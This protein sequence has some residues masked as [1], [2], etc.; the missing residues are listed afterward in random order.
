MTVG[1]A[2]CLFRLPKQREVKVVTI[3]RRKTDIYLLPEQL[4]V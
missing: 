4:D 2:Y 3:G 1:D